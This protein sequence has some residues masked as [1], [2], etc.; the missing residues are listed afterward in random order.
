MRE[1]IGTLGVVRYGCSRDELKM[2]MA[3]V[4]RVVM[5]RTFHVRGAIQEDLLIEEAINKPTDE[6]AYA[7]VEDMRTE[8]RIVLAAFTGE[9]APE[10]AEAWLGHKTFW[11]N[12]NV[13]A[14]HAF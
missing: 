12:P 8:L 11:D 5:E 2:L 3:E 4:R 1:N 6:C 14:E 10:T 7:V 9:I 13:N